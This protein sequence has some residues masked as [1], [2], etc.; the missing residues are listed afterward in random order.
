MVFFNHLGPIEY[1]KRQMNLPFAPSPTNATFLGET[2]RC[3]NAVYYCRK[4]LESTEVWCRLEVKNVEGRGRH[5]F[6]KG[7]NGPS[8]GKMLNE[9]ASVRSDNLRAEAIY[10]QKHPLTKKNE[11]TKG[12][13]F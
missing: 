12:K 6:R 4:T 9:S 11:F 8:S 5:C 3:T 13:R 1:Q 10:P 2:L 7:V